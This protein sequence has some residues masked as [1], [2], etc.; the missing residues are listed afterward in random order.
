ALS[1]FPAAHA[2][3]VKVSKDKTTEESTQYPVDVCTLRAAIASTE[4][5]PTN[6]ACSQGSGGVSRD[7][8]LLPAGEFVLWDTLKVN[9]N[10]PIEIR[11]EGPDKTT[12][13]MRDEDD[14]CARLFETE[15]ALTLSNLT[16]EGGCVQ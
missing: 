8:I 12:I 16:L 2:A 4:A 10:N 7:V 9:Q 13:T 6:T 15:S 5:P 14:F 3:E 11:G 1:A